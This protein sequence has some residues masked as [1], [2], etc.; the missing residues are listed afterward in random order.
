VLTV[1]IATRDRAPSLS[2]TLDALEV[3]DPPRGGFS[4][5]VVDDGSRD[6]TA[7]VIAARSARLPIVGVQSSPRGQNSARNLALARVQG[8]LVVFTDDDAEPRRDWLRRLRE[9]A[10]AHPEAAVVV[11]T[12]VPRFEATPPPWLLRS[13]RRG[14][15]FAWLERDADGFVDPTEGVSPSLAIRASVFAQGMRFDESIGPDGT[16]DYAMG[17]ETELLLRLQRRG[18]RAW[19]A[20]DAVV[21]H[22]VRAD[23]VAED[24]LISRAYR[25]GRGR[26]RL[27]TARLARARLAAFGVPL[28]L[29]AD[30]ASRRLAFAWA[31][32]RGA[33]AG[34][35]RSAW[36]LAFL[37]GHVAEVRRGRGRRGLGLSAA[38]LPASVRAAI[39]AGP[40]AGD[41]L[42]R[43]DPGPA[44]P[45]PA[46]GVR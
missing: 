5:V 40:S 42:G 31:R 41:R 23:Q 13:V 24:A 39:V 32:V 19:Y 46:A 35:M 28:A 20:R 34:A 22:V 8:D 7:D 14:P 2:R 1:V 4:I 45:A 38:L 29:V 30:L 9:A 44:F 37:A 43:R 3:L 12:V 27:G 10:D 33:K 21:E 16:G 6:G 36:R 25:Y 15:S 18:E 17:S 26:W 11:G